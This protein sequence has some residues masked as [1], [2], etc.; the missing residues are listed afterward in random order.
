MKI[1]IACSGL[2]LIKRGVEAWA[3]DLASELHRRGADITLFQGAGPVDR[4][5]KSVVFTFN[6]RAWAPRMLA[7][8]LLRLGLWRVMLGSPVAIEQ[9]LFSFNLWRKVRKDY[10]VLHVQDH[11]IAFWMEWLHRRGRSRPKVIF[12]NGVGSSDAE[13]D[14]FST[15]QFVS[16]AHEA[17][18]RG[19]PGPDQRTF[20][21][22]NFVD[23]R[24]FGT[25]TREEARA[26]LSIPADAFVAVGVSAITA[27]A[28]RMDYTLREISKFR[29]QHRPDAYLVVAG[30]TEPDT[31]D[32]LD[33]GD[34]LLGDRV[35]FLTDVPRADMPAIYG[36][37]DVFV[38]GSLYEPFGIVLLEALASGVPVVCHANGTMDWIVG[39][40]GVCGDFS[41]EGRMCEA[42]RIFDER[43]QRKDLGAEGRRR[44]EQYFSVQPVVDEVE[45]MYRACAAT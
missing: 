3:D 30:A 28:K 21:I 39:P 33:L 32:L 42:L 34:E 18:R 45:K 35:R 38:H 36:A 23:P 10:D 9:T 40:A 22:P 24:Q 41:T 7:P 4:P 19:R 27:K 14:F 6:R 20:V 1:A 29:A 2:P 5:Y 15:L 13:M 8:V 43:R 11:V 37:A 17:A 44:V 31:Q 12:A 26:R 16:P 25:M